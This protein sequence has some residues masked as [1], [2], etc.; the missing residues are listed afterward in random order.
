MKIITFFFINQNKFFF[1][2][3]SRKSF[4]IFINNDFKKYLPLQN[5]NFLE[6]YFKMIL[7]F[8]EIPI[9]IVI[10]PLKN[11]W[12][13]Q[14]SFLLWLPQGKPRTGFE[15]FSLASIK[16]FGIF[17]QGFLKLCA[18]EKLKNKKKWN[19]RPTNIL[20]WISLI[21]VGFFFLS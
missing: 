19:L 14:K 5:Q 21:L 10:E 8:S 12:I 9:N 11:V 3:I 6:N 16:N 18:K 7:N 17:F 20:T 1:F 13:V 2:E 15:K 4:P